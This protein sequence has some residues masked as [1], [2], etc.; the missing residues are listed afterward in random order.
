MLGVACGTRR[1]DCSAACASLRAAALPSGS[2]VMSRSTVARP[3]WLG[4]GL[5]LGCANP[6]PNPNPNPHPS[7]HPNPNPNP[8]PNP[9]RTGAGRPSTSWCRLEPPHLIA[10]GA[11]RG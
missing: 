3:T 4:L 10:G 8:N 11:V 2:Q 6:N 9:S 5:G 1:R 7:P